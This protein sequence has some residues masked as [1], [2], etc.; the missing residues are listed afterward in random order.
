M[1]ATKFGGGG[2]LLDGFHNANSLKNFREDDLH[3]HMYLLHSFCSEERL[4]RVRNGEHLL[5]TAQRQREAY[6][7]LKK[8][9]EQ[10]NEPRVFST[11]LETSPGEMMQEYLAHPTFSAKLEVMKLSSLEDFFVV[12]VTQEKYFQTSKYLKEHQLNTKLAASSQTLKTAFDQAP[13]RTSKRAE[14]TENA[15]VNANPVAKLQAYYAKKISDTDREVLEALERSIEGRTG[16]PDSSFEI[17][18]KLRLTK[19][20]Q[21]RSVAKANGNKVKRSPFKE[22]LKPQALLIPPSKQSTRPPRST[23]PS[24]IASL[25]SLRG[26]ES[27]PPSLDMQEARELVRNSCADLRKISSR[28]SR[29]M[30]KAIS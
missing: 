24:S 26:G 21:V 28:L 23:R 29:A 8:D 9:K 12:S 1:K 11:E 20:R 5:V 14:K 16:L 13:R 19:R 6:L 4:L 27:R 2:N 30:T 15:Q 22:V 17:G 10:F 25:P 7:R 18:S 3:Y